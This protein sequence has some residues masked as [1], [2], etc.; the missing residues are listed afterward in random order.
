MYELSIIEYVELVKTE[1]T[2]DDINGHTQFNLPYSHDS[3]LPHMTPEDVKNDMT[4]IELPVDWVIPWLGVCN[5][6]YSGGYFKSTKTAYTCASLISP[7]YT[8][9]IKWH[10]IWHHFYQNY[11]TPT[12]IKK[13]EQLWGKTKKKWKH[14]FFREYWMTNADEWFADIFSLIHTKWPIPKLS[15]LLAKEAKRLLASKTKN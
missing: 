11:L 9:F 12:D 1:I 7:W 5:Q 13:W 15:K 8:E 10:E 2:Q 6:G 3:Q 4:V 14:N